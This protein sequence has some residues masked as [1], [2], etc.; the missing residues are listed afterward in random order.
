MFR[1]ENARG[2]N[3]QRHVAKPWIW[4]DPTP[5]DAPYAAVCL[6]NGSTYAGPA[7]SLLPFAEELT[8]G[9]D[10]MICPRAE[11]LRYAIRGSIEG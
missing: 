5:S 3:M 4:A 2:V 10:M 7:D 1:V 6:K 9:A 11:A 8:H